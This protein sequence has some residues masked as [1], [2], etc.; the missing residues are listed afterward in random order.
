MGFA[1]YLAASADQSSLCRHLLEKELQR[2]SRMAQLS[3]DYDLASYP[4]VHQSTFLRIA[5]KHQ[6]KDAANDFLKS[7][8]FT[9]PTADYEFFDE[10]A[11]DENQALAP[12]ERQIRRVLT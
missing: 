1:R 8:A 11:D 4:T 6:I 7:A 10:N 5:E 2:V 9:G 12:R 3:M